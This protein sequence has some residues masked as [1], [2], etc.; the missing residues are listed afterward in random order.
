MFADYRADFPI[1]RDNPLIYFD[2]AATAQKPQ[3]VI[4]SL[5][6]F[7]TT[8]YGTV[9]RGVYELSRKATEQYE[10]AREKV[11]HFLNARFPEEIIFTRG[12]TAS[13]NLVARSF[14]KAFAK[15]GDVI[16]IPEIEHHSNIV[17]WQML[18][19]EKG[20][21]LKT[22]PILD[23]GELDIEALK[24]LLTPEVILVSLAHISNTLGTLHPL[25]DIIRLVHQRGAK[26]C[27][28]G[29]QAAGHVSI[30]LQALD[31]DFY[32][33]SGHKLYG[34]TG[35]GVLFGKRE[36]LEKMPPIEGG[37]DMIEKVTW[38]KTTYNPLP[39]KFEAGTPLVAPV[40]G[41]GAAIDYIESLGWDEIY[42]HEQ[43]L[44]QA[45]TQQLNSL[46]GVHIL[47]GAPQKG[48]IITFTIE[49]HHP[50]DIATLLD[51]RGIALRSGH[52][53]SQP[54]MKRFGISSALRL[55]FGLYNNLGEIERFIKAL[56]AFIVP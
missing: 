11:R 37:G 5:T 17:P 30:D 24:G 33:F 43:T 19:Q 22:I 54:T 26:V 29:A 15:A 12:T 34:P 52:L 25:R 20:C 50:L 35:V 49:R 40:I 28:D 21:I 27:V 1:F 48:G 7:Y 13:L 36:L 46:S 31:A 10:G 44:L 47:G 42:R 3:S 32:A 23:S 2:T 18:C 45:A 55:S 39:L 16:L 56:K 38:E 9:H 51:C 41:L 53:C 14:G 4:D 8:A 6:T